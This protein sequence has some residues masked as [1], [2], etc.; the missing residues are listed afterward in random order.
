MHR[1]IWSLHKLKQ[2]G[3]ESNDNYLD[4]FKSQLTALE[5]AGG[6]HLFTSPD[7]SNKRI[8]DMSEKQISK[9]ADK[10]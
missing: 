1:A 9:L 4:R 6:G 7:I 3:T 10:S 8:E 2:G 5:L